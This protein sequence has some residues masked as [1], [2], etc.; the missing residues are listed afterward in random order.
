MKTFFLIIAFL[1]VGCGSKS[2]QENHSA[3]ATSPVTESVPDTLVPQETKESETQSFDFDIVIKRKVELEP[4]YYNQVEFKKNINNYEVEFIAK[5]GGL[6][7][8]QVSCVKDSFDRNPQELKSHFDLRGQQATINLSLLETDPQIT[9]FKCGLSQSQER[10]TLELKKSI[11]ITGT[12]SALSVLGTPAK[13]QTIFMEKDSELITEGAEFELEIDELHSFGGQISTFS[14]E[15]FSQK[16][17]DLHRGLPG[18]HIKLKVHKSKGSLVV[19]LVGLP[20][21]KNTNIIPPDSAPVSPSY[22]NG[23]CGAINP[24]SVQECFG[25]MGITGTNGREGEPGIQGGDSGKLSF[26]GD[27][28]QLRLAVYYYPGKGGMGGKGQ[29]GSPGGQ[30]GIGSTVVWREHGS[31]PTRTKYPDGPQGNPG[32]PGKQGPTGIIGN[33]EESQINDE[34]ISSSWRN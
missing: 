25:R 28:T 5:S 7:L 24:S 33:V 8:A 10:T 30:G 4:S 19:N 14:Q 9:K 11:V 29:E 13:Y 32:Q 3:P 34:I 21:G 2:S 12:Q 16:A 27:T 22:V 17:P 15:K 23:N 31:S 26:K 18:G 1:L 20:S 6:S